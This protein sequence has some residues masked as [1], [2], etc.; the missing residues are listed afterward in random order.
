[1]KSKGRGQGAR[2]RGKRALGLSGRTF[3]SWLNCFTSRTQ[4][5]PLENGNGHI[6]FCHVGT[7]AALTREKQPC[8][9]LVLH[10]V[11]SFIRK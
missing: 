4:D 6:S 5:P 9:I 3:A 10:H 2:F 8:L 11:G 7:P 1:M